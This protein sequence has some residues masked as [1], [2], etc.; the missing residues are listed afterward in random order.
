VKIGD[1]IEVNGEDIGGLSADIHTLAV[2]KIR[3]DY[4][5]RT[6]LL[7]CATLDGELD[8]LQVF[9]SEILNV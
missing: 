7:D 1:H 3:K 9:P 4:Y 6:V 2:T 5:G 8:N